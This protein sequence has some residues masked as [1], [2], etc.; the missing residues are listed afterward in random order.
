[1]LE[2]LLDLALDVCRA[3]SSGV[4]VIERPPDHTDGFRWIQTAGAFASHAGSMVPGRFSPSG[5][6]LERHAPQLFLRPARYFTP[7]AFAQPPICETLVVQ[8]G[9]G[10]ERLGTIWLAAHDPNRHFDAEDVRILSVLGGFTA[11]ALRTTEL[12]RQSVTVNE[13]KDQFL[14]RLSHELRQP[15]NAILGWV[16]L[17]RLDALDPSSLGRA[18]DAIRNNTQALAHTLSDVVDFSHIANRTFRIDLRAVDVCAVVESLIAALAPDRDH[19]VAIRCRVEHPV[20]FVRADEHRLRQ[21]VSNLIVNAVKF[22]PDEAAIDVI[23]REVGDQVEIAVKDT[24]V[25]IR[26]S[27]RSS[28]SPSANRPTGL[29]AASAGSASA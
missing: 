5:F 22:S 29:P 20:R 18:L 8:V 9:R 2:H 28:S 4:S 14:I 23:V 11:A 12:T 13:A 21:I 3:S 24:G 1:L 19:R 27:S 17:L 10:G 26:R 6:T 15:L 16:D 25:G 7:L